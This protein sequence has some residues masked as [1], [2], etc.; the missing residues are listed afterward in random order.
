MSTGTVIKLDNVSYGSFPE[1][2]YLGSLSSNLIRSFMDFLRSI[3]I[4]NLES[5]KTAMPHSTIKEVEYLFL[6]CHMK[7]DIIPNNLDNVIEQRKLW[8]KKTLKSDRYSYYIDLKEVVESAKNRTSIYQLN[9]VETEVHRSL[10]KKRREKET[11]FGS[12]NPNDVVRI[13]NKHVKE[14]LSN[15]ELEPIHSWATA[16]HNPEYINHLLNSIFPHVPITIVAQYLF[17]E[18]N[19]TPARIIGYCNAHRLIRIQYER[20]CIHDDEIYAFVK[21]TGHDPKKI[22]EEEFLKRHH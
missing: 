9:A 5:V 19:P 7:T 8:Q 14:I 13:N 22:P 11:R 10:M 3:G 16:K 21:W 4:C 6:K 17:T 2:S 15:C 18:D 20:H 12:E 1:A